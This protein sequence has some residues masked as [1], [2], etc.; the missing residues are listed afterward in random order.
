M[1]REVDDHSD[2]CMQGPPTTTGATTVGW[3][4]ASLLAV[5]LDKALNGIASTFEWLDW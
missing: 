4:P 3:M 1:T 5:S 2:P